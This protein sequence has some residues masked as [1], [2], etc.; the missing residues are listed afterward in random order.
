MTLYFTPQFKHVYKMSPM[1]FWLKI[2]KN[3]GNLLIF[4]QNSDLRVILTPK[5]SKRAQYVFFSY[6]AVSTYL[7]NEPFGFQA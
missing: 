1:N 6:P 5:S 4:A 2:L 7:H 3:K